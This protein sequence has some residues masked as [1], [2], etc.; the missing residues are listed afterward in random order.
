[1]TDEICW[2]HEVHYSGVSLYMKLESKSC[3]VIAF[4]YKKTIYKNIQAEITEE[5]EHP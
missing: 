4:V 3:S 2:S 1:M 5:K